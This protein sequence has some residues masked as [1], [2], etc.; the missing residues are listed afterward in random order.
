MLT[1]PP[2]PAAMASLT[3][4]PILERLL[5]REDLDTESVELVFGA[6][7]DGALTSAQ[8]AA[9][10]IALRAKGETPEEIAAAARALRSRASM[11]APKLLDGAPLVDT[12]GTGGDGAH[13]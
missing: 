10:A 7:L 2:V 11:I 3:L 1:A 9:F 12:C 6:I 5:A 13:I 4:S 8:I